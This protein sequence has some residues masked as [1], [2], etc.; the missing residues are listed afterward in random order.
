MFRICLRNLKHSSCRWLP[1]STDHSVDDRVVEEPSS[2]GPPRSVERCCL[3]SFSLT[4]HRGYRVG[5]RR[6][7]AYTVGN[8][9]RKRGWQ[10]CRQRERASTK[11]SG[12]LDTNLCEAK[13]SVVAKVQAKESCFALYLI[14][15]YGC[16]ERVGWSTCTR[17]RQLKRVFRSFVCFVV[18]CS[19]G[20]FHVI[21]RIF[22]GV[23]WGV[24]SY[25]R[26][27]QGKQLKH[28]HQ[29]FTCTPL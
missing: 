6:H 24:L 11:A 10:R 9:R 8:R 23:Q 1:R 15:V 13:A 27:A 4:A 12:W 14:L 18:V 17:V 16:N 29:P 26:T 20:S 25:R 3:A 28:L 19:L 2:P 7:R 22:Y 21:K 5:N